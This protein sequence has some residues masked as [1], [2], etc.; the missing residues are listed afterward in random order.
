MKDRNEILEIPGA[1]FRTGVGEDSIA[2]PRFASFLWRIALAALLSLAASF[3][4]ISVFTGLLAALLGIIV[5]LS[6]NIIA[7]LS[8]ARMPRRRSAS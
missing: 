6:F 7:V 2:E 8:F 5:T 3:A 4:L 1:V